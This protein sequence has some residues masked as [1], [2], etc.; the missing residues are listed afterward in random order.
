M[1]LPKHKEVH[2]TMTI[3][4]AE[5]FKKLRLDKGLTQEQAADIFCISPQAISRWECGT[6]TPD[7]SLLPAIADYFDVTIEE[8]LGAGKSRREEKICEYVEKFNT[9]ITHGQV[10][11]C[12]EIA[13]AGVKE[14]PNSYIL[15]NKLMYA[16]FVS[17]SD[18]ANIPDWKENMEKYKYEIIEL[19][20]KI[21]AGCTDDDIRIEAK[22]RLGFHYCEIGE[23][24]KGRQI[25]ETLPSM[26]FSREMNIRYALKDEELLRHLCQQ[27]I[28]LTSELVWDIWRYT[29]RAS[30]S[31]R[32]QLELMDKMEQIVRIVYDEEDLKGWY[33]LLPRFYI[34]GK[35]P[36]LLE[37]DDCEAALRLIEKSA[38]YLEQYEQ[39]PNRSEHT[40]LLLKYTPH[41]KYFHTADSRSQARILYEDNLSDHCFD[42]L[43]QDERFKRAVHRIYELG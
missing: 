9:A 29:K 16:L 15:L 34:I 25:L 38:D 43:R 26:I 10:T 20:E 17:G 12:I 35:A 8:L 24:E 41:N 42:T 13:R 1:L 2:T 22:S 14:F 18:D 7:I 31:V 21:L 4:F 30:I 36:L 28:L 23:Y 5:I 39:L 37:L 11:D 19:G 3:Y 32:E 33:Y 6:T 27:I 40:T